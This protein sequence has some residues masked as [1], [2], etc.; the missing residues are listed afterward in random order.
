M[1]EIAPNRTHY[2]HLPC[3]K[4][5]NNGGQTYRRRNWDSA[6]HSLTI[7]M[8]TTRSIRADLSNRQSWVARTA[9]PKPYRSSRKLER[10][11][12]QFRSLTTWEVKMHPQTVV[13]V[14][15]TPTL[16]CIQL[17]TIF[18]VANTVSSCPRINMQVTPSTNRSC[19]PTW[20][21]WTRLTGE[22]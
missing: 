15:T 17:H 22:T 20:R 7:A 5:Q 9:T 2:R 1:S 8:V 21:A 11:Q 3:C 14:W 18:P 12:G 19:F 6:D 10:I 4:A 13:T 16:Q